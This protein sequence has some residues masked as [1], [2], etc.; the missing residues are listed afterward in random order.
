MAVDIATQPSFSVARPKML[1]QGPYLRTPFTLP[2]YDVSLDGQHFLMLKPTEQT[3]S[4]PLTQI[5]VVQNC[6]ENRAKLF[7]FV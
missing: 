5:V 2:Y 7:L 6:S 1:F 3:S 4:S